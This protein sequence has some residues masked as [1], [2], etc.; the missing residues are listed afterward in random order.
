[1]KNIGPMKW[2][3]EE[4]MCVQLS[5]A[6]ANDSRPKKVNS[7]STKSRRMR[8]GRA[9]RL[10]SSY[11][12][13]GRDVSPQ[14]HEW[15]FETSNPHIPQ[16]LFCKTKRYIYIYISCWKTQLR[17]PLGF[18]HC[19]TCSRDWKH[20]PLINRLQRSLRELSL[21]SRVTTD[22]HPSVLLGCFPTS[23]HPENLVEGETWVLS[24]SGLCMTS[25]PTLTHWYPHPAQHGSHPLP[26]ASRGPDVSV[27]S[28]G[29]GTLLI[30]GFTHNKK[31]SF[32]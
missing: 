18:F 27:V 29:M 11:A 9:Q 30:L 12:E 5:Q 19:K 14:P 17:L 32:G 10:I 26:K 2:K 21:W 31:R 13:G 25:C 4:H 6:F 7:S 20:S 15:A 22:P 3:I 23:H 1:M 28:S 8:H 16:K 24:T